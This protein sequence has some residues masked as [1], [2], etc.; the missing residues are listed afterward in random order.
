[1]Y[2][3][4]G[5]KSTSQIIVKAKQVIRSYYKLYGTTSMCLTLGSVME[6]EGWV[7]PGSSLAESQS[8][9]GER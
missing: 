9:Q 7:G 6:T 8:R 4:G 3:V 1:M 2:K 5:I